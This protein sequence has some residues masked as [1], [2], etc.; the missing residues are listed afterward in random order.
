M[1]VVLP[2]SL[3]FNLFDFTWCFMV[4]LFLFQK[5]QHLTLASIHFGAVSAMIMLFLQDITITDVS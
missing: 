1:K 4:I 5:L 2:S 3:Y